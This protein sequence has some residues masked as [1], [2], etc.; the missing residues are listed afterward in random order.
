MGTSL[1]PHFYTGF[2]Q[3]GYVTTDVGQA[4]ANL[5]KNFGVKNFLNI[6]VMKSD[7]FLAD[8]RAVTNELILS[9]ANVGD[10]QVEL[11]Q[12]VNDPSGLYSGALPQ[13]DGFAMV[14]HHLGHRFF[15]IAQWNQFRSQLDL[16]SH[17]LAFENNG[18]AAHYVYTD[19]RDSLGH[20]LEYMWLDEQGSAL[21][22]AI[23]NNP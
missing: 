7:V 12:P 5:K 20:F 10:Q 11:I 2:F 3:F 23:P 22:D 17:K 1:F 9:F 13:R 19:E 4:E 21:F 16:N 14:L 6:G 15:D 18:G 8:G